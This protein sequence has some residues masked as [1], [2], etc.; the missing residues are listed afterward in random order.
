VDPN[1]N[2]G[3]GVIDFCH[4]RATANLIGPIKPKNVLMLGDGQYNSGTLAEYN[5]SYAKTWGVSAIKSI[6]KPTP[7]NH[8]YASPTAAGYFQYFGA[9]AHSPNGWYSF[10]LGNWHVVSINTNCTKLSGGA[11]CATGSPQDKWLAADLAA[12]PTACTLV[13]GHHPLWSSNSS[14]SPD[15]LPLMKTMYAGHVD[16]YLAGHS[17]SYE[18]FAPMTPSGALDTAHGVREL[19]VGTGGE[20]VT[21]FGTIAPNSQKR[22]N[23]IFGVEQLVLKSTS[24][25]LTFVNDTTNKAFSDSLAGTACH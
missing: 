20:S 17:H 21:G 22:G 3:A 1:Y 18:R 25:D 13:F 10:N 8:E 5:A 4:Q 11:G 23:H 6:T 7:G 24:Y 14:G 19:I 15:I 9:A 12:N 16:L 2:G